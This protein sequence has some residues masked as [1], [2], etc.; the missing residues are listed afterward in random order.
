MKT[1]NPREEH[2]DDDNNNYL[3][4]YLTAWSLLSQLLFSC[5]AWLSNIQASYLQAF[6]SPFASHGNN[7]LE[8]G[9][10]L[11][12]VVEK[13]KMDGI[14]LLGVGLESSGPLS[15]LLEVFM[16]HGIL[17]A[18]LSMATKKIRPII[19]IT[20]FFPKFLRGE[21]GIMNSNGCHHFILFYFI[22]P[23]WIINT[24]STP[25]TNLPPSC[26][27]HVTTNF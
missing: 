15:Y 13:Y 7:H 10:Q 22:L 5:G 8:T 3:K 4:Q 17:V 18:V 6:A 25:S 24:P 2:H 23:Q 16:P 11:D 9:L 20:F 1:R 26:I 21:D 19:C 14:D 12:V 27:C